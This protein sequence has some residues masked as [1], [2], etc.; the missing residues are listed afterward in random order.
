MSSANWFFLGAL[1]GVFAG[2]IRGMSYAR[3][4]KQR[5]LARNT[6]YWRASVSVDGTCNLI[7]QAPDRRQWIEFPQDEVDEMRWVAL[8]IKRQPE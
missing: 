2:I 4:C 1:V 8:S 6:G 3:T 5:P 7:R